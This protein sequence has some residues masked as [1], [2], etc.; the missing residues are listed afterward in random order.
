M[1]KTGLAGS[2]SQVQLQWVSRYLIHPGDDR[3][4]AVCGVGVRAMEAERTLP[5]RQVGL[6]RVWMSSILLCCCARQREPTPGGVVA[7]CEILIHISALTRAALT[8][9]SVL[10]YLSQVSLKMQHMQS[11]VSH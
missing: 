9:S 4:S 5:S 6:Q 7:V 11:I 2:N 8:D 1:D 3:L 10:V